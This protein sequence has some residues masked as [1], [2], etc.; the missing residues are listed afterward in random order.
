MAAPALMLNG[1]AGV[2]AAF[3]ERCAVIDA[4]GILHVI[5]HDSVTTVN[6]YHVAMNPAGTFGALQTIETDVFYVSETSNFL[7]YDNGG[8]DTISFVAVRHR[9]ST[10]ANGDLAIY[11]A[12]GGSLAPTWGDNALPASNPVQDPYISPDWIAALGELD[13][14]LYA[15]WTQSGATAVLGLSATGCGVIQHSTA[16]AT[17]LATWDAESTY[18]GR[19]QRDRGLGR[20]PGACLARPEHRAGRHRQL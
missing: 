13:G 18:M 9:T 15:F 17:D 11:T 20:R 12:A 4:S 3:V 8:T 10:R 1:Q 5:L 14:T 2:S 7:D 16:S 6:L 19:R